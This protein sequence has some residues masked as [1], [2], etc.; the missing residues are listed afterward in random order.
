MN[1]SIISKISTLYPATKLIT[2]EDEIPQGYMVYIL[3]Y[4]G[5]AIVV[6]Q[7]QADRA[8]VIFVSSTGKT[9]THYKS[10]L[11]RLYMRYESTGV[12]DRL[13]IPC[14]TQ[15][16][17]RTIEA[18]LHSLIGGTGI[19][20]TPA[21]TTALYHGVT[22]GSVEELLIK[23]ALLSSFDG[24]SDLRKWNNAGIINPKVWEVIQSKL[25]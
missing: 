10:M 14:K 13:I 1:K 11:V 5:S 17:A 21:I 16:D 19:N 9:P 20:L 18:N 25:F 23:Q 15:A 2:S 22:P 6:G 4:N 3:L 12:Y 8:K 7:G 24:L